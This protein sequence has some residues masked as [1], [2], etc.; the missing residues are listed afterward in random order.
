LSDGSFCSNG[1]PLSPAAQFCPVCGV[2]RADPSATQPEP[3]PPQPFADAG[4][5]PA[6]QPPY[7]QPPAGAPGPPFGTPS[8]PTPAWSQDTPA[9]QDGYPGPGAPVAPA[10]P[11]HRRTAIAVGAIAVVAAAAVIAIVI[12]ITRSS[13][14][15]GWTLEQEASYLGTC[16]GGAESTLFCLCSYDYLSKNISYSSYSHT[17]TTRS[18]QLEQQVL[19][20]CRADLS[21]GG[22]GPLSSGSGGGSGTFSGGS[23]S[24]GSGGFAS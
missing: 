6:G 17:G 15:N 9:H 18:R 14:D 16:S 12:L 24:F 1:H 2:G 20:A 11:R 5:P 22:S 21:T 8:P 7:A 4:P 23:G 10:G 13:G 3:N 19:T